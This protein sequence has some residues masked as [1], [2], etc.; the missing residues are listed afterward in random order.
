MSES[1]TPSDEP[2]L[3]DIV[4]RNGAFG[5]A[6]SLYNCIEGSNYLRSSEY[7]ELIQDLDWARLEIVNLKSVIEADH[8]DLTAALARVEKA[9]AHGH[10]LLEVVHWLRAQASRFIPDADNLISID[11]PIQKHK[12]LMDKI[13]RLE[14]TIEDY[15]EVSRHRIAESY[16]ALAA[17]EPSN[18]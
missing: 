6:Q 1:K 10:S 3:D 2:S 17:K 18:G 4:A 9:E 12:A 13:A 15:E 16:T 11:L 14:K 5:W 8:A 7:A